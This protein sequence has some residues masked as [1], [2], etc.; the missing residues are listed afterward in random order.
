MNL[1]F[2][3]CHNPPAFECLVCHER[4]LFMVQVRTHLKSVH[5]IDQYE[6]SF[7]KHANNYDADLAKVDSFL[8]GLK[9]KILDSCDD[10]AANN[11]N[12]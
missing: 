6:S 3:G 4:F 10:G 7:H 12:Q 11:M 8:E 1:L 9:N 5:G 2:L